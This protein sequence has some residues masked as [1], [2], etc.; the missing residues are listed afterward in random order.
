MYN[1][2]QQLQGIIVKSPSMINSSNAT[3]P[4]IEGG[5][6]S[7]TTTTTSSTKTSDIIDPSQISLIQ[8]QQQPSVVTGGVESMT[9]SGTSPSSTSS[10]SSSSSAAS[11]S[12]STTTAA[13]T[14]PAVAPALVAVPN[15]TSIS[16]NNTS[17]RSSDVSELPQTQQQPTTQQQPEV[18]HISSGIPTPIQTSSGRFTSTATTTASGYKPIMTASV[19]ASSSTSNQQRAMTAGA[20]T[21]KLKKA[22]TGIYLFTYYHP[23][24]SLFY[25]PYIELL[26]LN[27]MISTL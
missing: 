15:N 5:A 6:T 25:F 8:Q 18:K 11:S 26:D 12:S 24:F 3:Q 21:V 14:T 13:T 2:K 23:S 9:A 7:T 22:D 20:N 4:T 19:N 27:F 17:Y 1:K 16:S 10:S